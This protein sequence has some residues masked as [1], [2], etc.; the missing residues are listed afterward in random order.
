[1]TLV[2]A[3]LCN[4][5]QISS[6]Q[7]SG[8]SAQYHGNPALP[9]YIWR[10]SRIVAIGTTALARHAIASIASLAVTHCTHIPQKSLKSLLK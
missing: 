2:F 3:S 9:I 10:G 4:M 8:T 7:G 5:A 1:M 6:S